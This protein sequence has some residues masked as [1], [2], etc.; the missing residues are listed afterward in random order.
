MIKMLKN[1]IQFAILA[2]GKSSR[3]G[4]DKLDY[5]I[6]GKT[7]LQQTIE[8]IK[9]CSDFPILIIGKNNKISM[10]NVELYN[11]IQ[12]GSGPLRGIYTA[13]NVASA[14]YLFIIAGDMPFIQPAL[15]NYMS[16]FIR[17]KKHAILPLNKGF[18]EPL[19]AIYHKSLTHH[20]ETYLKRERYKISESL[21]N[22]DKIEISEDLWRQYDPHGLSFYNINTRND[23]P[24]DTKTQFPWI[25]TKKI[26]VE[27]AFLYNKI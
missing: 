6:N 13:L 9:D 15:T 12:L 23:L 19:F 20:F 2:G 3:F 25:V 18:Y 21:E 11:D 22:I 8:K 14:E 17:F 16:S 7:L 4:G 24:I 27:K 5:L 1:K 10:P 26:K